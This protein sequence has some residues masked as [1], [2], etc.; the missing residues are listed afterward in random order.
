MV[1][2]LCVCTIMTNTEAPSHGGAFDPFGIE[3]AKASQKP[4]PPSRRPVLVAVEDKKHKDTPCFSLL[5]QSTARR[6]SFG[7]KSSGRSKLPNHTTHAG[8]LQSAEQQHASLL[9]QQQLL[10]QPTSNSWIPHWTPLEID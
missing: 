2:S 8:R 3:A 7:T 4:H 5:S 10:L 1:V 6:E 9:Q